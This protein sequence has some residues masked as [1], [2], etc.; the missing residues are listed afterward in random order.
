MGLAFIHR[1][2]PISKMMN[3]QILYYMIMTTTN[4]SYSTIIISLKNFRMYLKKWIWS[5]KNA[6]NYMIMRR[7]ARLI[8]I[9]K[10]IIKW[11]Y[12]CLWNWKI[13]N[14]LVP[15]LIWALIHNQITYQDKIPNHFSVISK[16]IFTFTPQGTTE[17]IHTI[18]NIWYSVTGK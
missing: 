6:R 18:Q 17:L 10:S 2:N 8:F 12:F 15:L 7:W 5:S 14:Y 9:K 4:G 13:M 1:M 11:I 3:N 16:R